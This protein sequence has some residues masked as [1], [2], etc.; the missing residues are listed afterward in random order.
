MNLPCAY[1]LGQIEQK[2]PPPFP[3]QPHK[4]FNYQLKKIGEYMC[5]CVWCCEWNT[6]KAVLRSRYFYPPLFPFWPITARHSIL[7]DR[8][9][10]CYC[11]RVSSIERWQARGEWRVLIS[12]VKALPL[13][14]S[15]HSITHTIIRQSPLIN[16]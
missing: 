8:L 15:T 10:Q 16:N 13:Q 14:H 6:V 2:V 11:T 7:D 9:T 12:T 3:E 5:D 1:R 4:I